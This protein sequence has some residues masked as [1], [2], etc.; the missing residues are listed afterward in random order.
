MNTEFRSTKTLG[1]VTGSFLLLGVAVDG[2]ELIL[3]LI[4]RSYFPGVWTSEQEYTDSEALF[5]LGVV[6]LLLVSILV[7]VSTAV[8]FL[9][10]IHRSYSNLVALNVQSLTSTPGWAVGYWFIPILCLFKPLKIVN[11]I[12][13]SSDPSLE[14]DSTRFSF[15]ST[16]VT[17]GMWWAFWIIG[18]IAGNISLRLSLN[19]ETAAATEFAELLDLVLLPVWMVC[20]ALA[21]V[22]VREITSRQ[23]MVSKQI[24]IGAP[25]AP[26]TFGSGINANF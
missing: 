22:V 18:S 20:G 9:M 19:A 12:Y 11:E 1:F 13:H 3:S 23:E 5:V 16:T 7:F 21:F 25:P 2:V 17:H 8:T 15:D 10:W 26:P 14:P 24:G 6:A 4:Q